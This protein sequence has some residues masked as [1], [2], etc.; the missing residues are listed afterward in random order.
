M[1]SARAREALFPADLTLRAGL[2]WL[3][4]CAIYL[5]TKWPAIAALALPDADDT[6]RMV[7]V[8]DLLAG[9]GWWDLHQYRIDPPGGIL[10]HWSRLVDLP[11]YLVQ[12]GLRPLLGA[13][14]AER[15]AL[16]VVPLL[17]LGCALLLAARIAWRKVDAELVFY[18][19]LVLALATPVTGQLQPLRIDHHGWQIV[20]VLAALNGLAADTARRTGWTC[21]AALALGMTISL[22]LLPVAALLGGVFALR[23]LTDPRKRGLPAAYLQALVAVGGAAFL[24]THGLQDLTNHC[25]SLSP[26]YL[27]ALAA[28]A[29]VATGL[30]LAPPLPRTVLALGYALCGAAG[31]AAILMIAPQCSTGPFAALDPLVQQFWYANVHEGMPVWLQKPPVIAQ[32]IVPPLIGLWAATKLWRES[33]GPLRRFWGE[34]ALVLAGLVLLAV[35]VARASAFACAAGAV[36]LAWQV[37]AWHRRVRDMR[38]PVHR[39]AGLVAIAVAVMPGVPLLAIGKL[40]AARQSEAPSAPAQLACDIPAAAPA[41]NRLAPAT[42]FAPID[43]GPVLLAQTRHKVIATAHH[44]APQALHDVIAAFIADPAEARSIVAAHSSRYVV[45]CPGLI[46]VSNYRNAA[47]EGLMA[48]LVAGKAPDWLRPVALPGGSGLQLWEVQIPEPLPGQAGRNT[49]ASPFMQ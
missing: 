23:A 7:Q 19:C 49:S 28:A 29:L 48:R 25:D 18:T 40:A 36:P 3:I 10:M 11:L 41:L 26:V 39:V 8:R 31:G 14:L 33:S 30:A 17:T 6:L 34:Y 27:A 4:V 37:R 13:Q 22:E 1:N 15:A 2:V 35:L 5:V 45:L 16:V 42:F 38:R 24:A 9:Q 32:M 47:P 46:E 21:G 20:A 43:I 44:R 12:L